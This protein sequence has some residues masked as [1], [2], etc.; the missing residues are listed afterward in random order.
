MALLLS[1][2]GVWRVTHRLTQSQTVGPPLCERHTETTLRH[3]GSLTSILYLQRALLGTR[4][5]LPLAKGMCMHMHMDMDM[6]M[7]MD[8]WTWMDMDMVMDTCTCTCTCTCMNHDFDSDN[9]SEGLHSHPTAL[10][11][12]G[13]IGLLEWIQ[14]ATKLPSHM[15]M[16]M[17]MH[18][19]MSHTVV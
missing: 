17:H 14:T 3:R 9:H 2:C 1:E 13:C 6:D 12:V 11:V 8:I 18:M 16:H 15:Y 5:A 19:H 4:R 10:T 7:D